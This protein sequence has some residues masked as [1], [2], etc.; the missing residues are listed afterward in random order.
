VGGEQGFG[1]RR[2]ARRLSHPGTCPAGRAARGGGCLCGGRRCAH[3]ECDVCCRVGT[4]GLGQRHGH[5][6]GV[7][8]ERGYSDGDINVRPHFQ[9]RVVQV[10]KGWAGRRGGGGERR[11]HRRGSVALGLR[12]LGPSRDGPGSGASQWRRGGSSCCLIRVQR[13]TSLVGIHPPQPRSLGLPGYDSTLTT[14]LLEIVNPLVSICASAPRPKPDRMS[15]SVVSL[16]TATR[17]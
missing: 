10:V 17:Q 3:R 1:T 4:A 16:V 7:D 5:A 12:R 6:G 2:R 15:A 11:R 8:V 14:L 13:K 9:G